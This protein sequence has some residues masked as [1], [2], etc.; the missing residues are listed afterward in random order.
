ME[1]FPGQKY[2]A[3]VLGGE[4]LKGVSKT[5]AGSIPETYATQAVAEER[6]PGRGKNAIASEPPSATCEGQQNTHLVD[7]VSVN[8]KPTTIGSS[9]CVPKVISAT[10]E[11][12]PIKS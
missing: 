6:S 2:L 12:L 5:V 11:S 8:P 3:F 1:G 10:A 7:C 9:A 4:V